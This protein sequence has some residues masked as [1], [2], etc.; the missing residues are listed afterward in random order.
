MRCHK[1]PTKCP[2]GRQLKQ[3]TPTTPT[4]ATS[5]G[6]LHPMRGAA[7]VMWRCTR[8]VAV[9]PLCGGAPEQKRC[10]A[11]G[12]GA[13]PQHTRT[14]A[15]LA[16]R[17]THRHNQP[18]RVGRIHCAPLTLPH[19]ERRAGRT[20]RLMLRCVDTDH[21][22]PHRKLRTAHPCAHSADHFAHNTPFLPLFAEVDCAVSTT[23]AQTAIPPQAASPSPKMPPGSHAIAGRDH[24]DGDHMRQGPHVTS[25]RNTGRSL[26]SKTRT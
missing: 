7:P 20:E 10:I 6:A 1:D 2:S 3:K 16:H 9:H 19:R 12:S 24:R 4:A 15:E 23:S 5:T 25:A 26:L 18:G 8:Y 13:V 21:R 11:Y 14:N 17:T 22:E